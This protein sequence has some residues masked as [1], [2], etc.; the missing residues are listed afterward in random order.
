[1]EHGLSFSP[2]N[3]WLAPLA[4]WSDLPFRLVCKELGASV[5]CSEMLSAK[6]LVY[7]GR[8]TQDLLI[9]CEEDGP[10]VMQI[11]GAEAPFMEKAIHILRDK[12]FQ[13]FDVNMGCSV[14][15]VVKTGAGAAMLKDIPN[16]LQVAKAVISASPD[17]SAG[18]KIRLGYE[19]NTS[20]FYDLA[21][22]LQDL[23]AGWISLHPRYAKQLFTGTADHSCFDE[24]AKNL[25]IPLI[26]S[27][28]LFTAQDG[29]RAIQEHGVSTVMYARGAL[30]NPFIFSQHKNLYES[31]YKSPYKSLK[32]KQNGSLGKNLDESQ[33]ESPL[34]DMSISA[35]MLGTLVRRHLELAQ[36]YTPKTC[37]LKM[38]TIVPRYVKQ[39]EGAKALRMEL[40]G[41]RDFSTLD[42]ILDKYFPN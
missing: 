41:C 11:F 32:G 35:K 23:G 20:V 6:G 36:I 21:M 12:G 2:E 29:V 18:F 10:V 30:N 37:L 39:M 40:I 26:A 31:L 14:P 5:T 27:G 34:N 4:G 19:M 8:N 38:R 15:K 13:Y 28:D 16:L 24:L 3:P 17:Q 33:N 9:T 22:R 42:Q 1:M 7:G 25:S